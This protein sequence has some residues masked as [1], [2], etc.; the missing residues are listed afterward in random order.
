LLAGELHEQAKNTDRALDVYSRY[1]EQFPAPVETAVETRS[2]IAEICKARHDDQGY[3]GALEA[4]VRADKEAGAE[5]TDRT[6][7]LAA[8][9]ALVLAEPRFERFA[10]LRLTQ[11]FERSLQD[12][13]QE[14]DAALTTF[15]NLVAYEVGDVTAAATF[16][17]AEIYSNFSQ[18][19]IESERPSGLTAKAAQDYE[20]ALE[21]EAYPFEEKAIG[22]HEKN[23]ELM[24]GGVYN[25]WVEK[26]LARLA[27]LMPARYAKTEISSGFL[28]A[29]DRYTYRVPEKPVIAVDAPSTPATD[30]T[31]PPPTEGAP[32]VPAPSVG[33]TDAPSDVELGVANANAP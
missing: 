21:D 8:R 25:A 13:R 29:I 15:S 10:A 17:M 7:N 19:L 20:L 18:S 12:K 3:R 24:T 16:Y 32:E 2:K 30:E 23:V 1:V 5:R 28:D 14:M 33:E 11:P 26:S 22:V 31:A 9:G 6:R 27:T 4:I